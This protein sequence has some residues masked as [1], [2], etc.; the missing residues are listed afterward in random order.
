MMSLQTVFIAIA[1]AIKCL[2]SHITGLADVNGC[3]L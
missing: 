2:E 1:S 3:V